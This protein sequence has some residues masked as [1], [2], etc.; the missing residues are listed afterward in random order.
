MAA[1]WLTTMH[2]EQEDDAQPLSRIL[3]GQGVM[4]L[5]EEE[6][7][8]Q[9][10]SDRGNHGPRK[11][12]DDRRRDDRREVDD[13]RIRDLDVRLE[14]ATTSDA[15]TSVPTATASDRPSWR[16]RSAASPPMLSG[17][18]VRPRGQMGL[19]GRL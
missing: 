18:A 19:R 1:S 2:E 11:A 17:D 8:K 14:A 13:R 12:G 4:R 3:D 5:R 15:A 9:E 6:V 16:D 10:R 7:V